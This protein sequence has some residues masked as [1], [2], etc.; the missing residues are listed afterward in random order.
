[1]RSVFYTAG[2]VLLAFSAAAQPSVRASVERSTFTRLTPFVLTIEISGSDFTPPMIPDIDGLNI[3][4]K[5]QSRGSSTQVS[6]VNGRTTMTKTVQI[7]YIIQATRTG[8]FTIPSLSVNVDGQQLQT[9]PIVI[10]VVDAPAASQGYGSSSQAP[11]QGGAQ[12]QLTWE[13]VVFIESSVDKKEVFQGEPILLTLSVWK[14][15]LPGLRVGQFPGQKVQMPQAEGFYATQPQQSSSQAERKKHNY[16]IDML[17]QTLYPTTAGQ[18]R[19]G[20]WH[21]E[22]GADYRFQSQSF[23]LDTQPIDIT[24]KPLPAQP[25]EFSGAVGAFRFSAQLQNNQLMQGVPTKLIIKIAGRGNPDAIGAPQ[26]Q[27]LENAYVT[28]PEKSVDPID[29]AGGPGIEKTFTYTVTPLEAGALTIPEISFCYFDPV[30]ATFRTDRAGPFQAQVLAAVETAPRVVISPNAQ[31]EQSKVDVLGEDIMP[32]ITVPGNLHQTRSTHPAVPV[33]IATPALAYC[34][35]ALFVRRR[36]RF[37]SDRGYARG[38]FARSKALKRLHDVSSAKEPSEQ[39]Y[40]TVIDFVADE[41]DIAAS[42]LTSSDVEQILRGH[43]TGDDLIE[44]FR[45]IL[46]ACERARYASVKLSDDELVGLIQ[47]AENAI[48]RLDDSAKKERR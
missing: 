36:R 15:Q 5:A 40:R 34:G 6:I 7:G 9:N 14:L 25:P 46:R 20:P 21:W 32:V 29:T 42:G 24:V 45:R 47:A 37:E 22:G 19:V 3:N 10:T 38:Y 13:D 8:K 30:T 27:K 23:S 31:L 44:G 4:K 18:L 39:L 43:S 1:M 48:V 26:V 2:I 33:V 35:M 41:F 16:D 17:T 28:E 11:D 12:E